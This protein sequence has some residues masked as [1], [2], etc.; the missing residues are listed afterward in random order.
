[1][2]EATRQLLVEKGYSAT[3][4]DGIAKLA[5]VGRPSIYRRWPSKAH[6]VNDT[7]HPAV[8]PRLDPAED[9]AEE[10]TRVVAGA[11]SVFA[12]AATREAAPGLMNDVR[13]E[14]SLRDA[15]ISG[16]LATFAGEL[17]QRIS[18]AVERGEARPGL[19]ANILI[20]IIAGAAIFAL[21]VRDVEDLE[22]LTSGLTEVLL[23]G[24]LA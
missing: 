9:F 12:D 8:L 18:A 2:F 15:L 23:R 14:S 24:I 17:G 3:T 11:I 16:Q 5:E 6:I 7:I 13:S 1:M 22:S 19:D 21:S 10:I 4:I 20:D